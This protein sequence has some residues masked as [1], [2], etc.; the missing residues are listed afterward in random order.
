MGIAAAVALS[1]SSSEEDNNEGSPVIKSS[2][3]SSGL[4]GAS[5]F[6]FSSN[7]ETPSCSPVKNGP[8]RRRFEDEFKIFLMRLVLVFLV[9][10]K[11]RAVQQSSLLRYLVAQKNRSS[12][13]NLSKLM[14]N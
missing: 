1:D 8:R 3:E 13:S 4:T 2:T 5:G 10:S 11:Y 6:T 7:F 9:L 14:N 12:T